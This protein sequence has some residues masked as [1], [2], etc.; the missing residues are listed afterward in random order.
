MRQAV[1]FGAGN[2]GRGF[3]GQLLFEGGYHTTF[4]D[5]NPALVTALNERGEYPLRLVSEGETQEHRIGNLCALDARADAAE[6]TRAVV[7][8]DLL[9]TAVGVAVL[10]HVASALAR[11]IAT[12]AEAGCGPIDVLLC[13]NQWHAAALMRGLIETHLPPSAYDYF[14]TSVGLVETVIGRM[15]PAPTDALRAENPLLVVSEPYKELP[16]ARAMLRGEPPPLPGLIAADDFD[17]YEARKLFLHNAGHAALAYLGYSRGHEYVWQCADDPTVSEVCRAALAE[18]A[19]ALVA[20]YSFAPASLDAFNADLLRRFTNKAPGRS[21]QPRGRRPIAETAPDRPAG[22]G[23]QP[24]P[25]A[26]HRAE[27]SGPRHR[28]CPA[29]RPPGRT[30][31]LRNYSGGV[32]KMGWG[33]CWRKWVALRRGRRWGGWC[34]RKCKPTH[35]RGGRDREGNRTG[36]ANTRFALPRPDRRA[37][38]LCPP[39]HLCIGKL[40]LCPST[41]VRSCSPLPTTTPLSTP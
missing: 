32:R 18:S 15:V 33:R 41:H 23:G 10:P 22:R 40:N 16:I 37:R 4:V 21:G 8:A 26:R 24:V 2:V 13:E 35:R 5:A 29:L 7:Q 17:A 25:E 31:P 12:R 1:A 36:R 39:S 38:T 27:R 9:L 14:R 3:L 28:R 30:P 11:G 19:A 6:I 20:E 34:W